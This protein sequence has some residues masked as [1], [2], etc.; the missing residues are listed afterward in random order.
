MLLILRKIEYVGVN[1]ALNLK[2]MCWKKVLSD[3]F[4]LSLRINLESKKII[5]FSCSI[6]SLCLSSWTDFEAFCFSVVFLL[7]AEIIKNYTFKNIFYLMEGDFINDVIEM[8]C[9]K[10]KWVQ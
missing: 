10:N 9:G 7:H 5:Y 3:A 8:F 6:S 1:V 4:L 2:I